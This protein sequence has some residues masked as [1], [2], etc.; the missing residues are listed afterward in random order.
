MP[1]PASSAEPL[2]PNSMR[3]IAD[4]MRGIAVSSRPASAYCDSSRF[5]SC[6]SARAAART[7]AEMHG[8]EKSNSSSISGLGHSPRGAQVAACVTYS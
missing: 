1:T 6:G 5:G 7:E 3:G 4:S 2:E 8:H